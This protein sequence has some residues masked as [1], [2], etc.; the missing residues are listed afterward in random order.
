MKIERKLIYIVIGLILVFGLYPLKSVYAESYIR[1]GDTTRYSTAVAIA[2]EYNAGTAPNI[3]LTTGDGFADALSAAPFAYQLNAPVLLSSD[4]AET[5]SDAV[6]YI[7]SHTISSSVTYIIGGN[8]SV[9]ESISNALKTKVIRISGG[10]RYATNLKLAVA[11]NV[12]KGTPLVFASGES[13]PDALCIAGIAAHNGYPIL[14]IGPQG[15]TPELTDYILADAPK[16]MYFIGGDAVLPMKIQEALTSALPAASIL[17]LA[18]NDR[19]ETAAA[20]NNAFESRPSKV[21]ITTG[22]DF[23][24]ALAASSLTARDQAPLIYE[25]PLR[26]G[27]PLAMDRYL[28]AVYSSGSTPSVVALGGTHASPDWIVSE[29]AST[30]SGAIPDA[31]AKFNSIGSKDFVKL[32]D[33]VPNALYD[34]RYMTTNNFMSTVLYPS[35]YIPTVRKDMALRLATVA[36]NLFP[37]GYRLKFWDAYRPASAQQKMW[38]YR[39]DANYI[40]NPSGWGSNHEHGGAVDVTLTDLAGNEIQMPTDFDDAT[41]KASRSYSQCTL[42]QKANALILQNAMQAQGFVGLSTEWWHFDD[43]DVANDPLEDNAAPIDLPSPSFVPQATVMISATGDN[44]LANGYQFGYSGSFNESYDNNGPSYFYQKVHKILSQGDLSLGNLEGVLTTA[45]VRVDKSAQGEQAFWFKGRPVY[46]SAL[47]KQA[48]YDAVNIANNHSRDYMDTGFYDTVKAL[49][50]ADVGYFGYGHMYTT[51]RKGVK[52]AVLGYNVIGETEQFIDPNDNTKLVSG[53]QQEVI[54]AVKTDI[55]AAKSQGNQLVVVYYHWGTEGN[56]GVDEYQTAIGHATVDA[57]ANLVLGAH[58]H[59]LE[60]TEVYHGT[61]IVYSL[62][63]FVFGGNYEL[64]DPA[65]EISQTTFTYVNG[66]LWSTSNKSIPCLIS[67]SSSVNDFQ[68]ELNW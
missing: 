12:T 45:T 33:Y 64:Y 56:N 18:G 21:Y 10:D 55:A 7:N 25:E 60:P 54:N 14:L 40:A 68:P 42:E 63:N 20:V 6:N 46:A 34:I 49:E 15:L 8:V 19:Y 3:V 29:V 41:T 1:I 28:N 35:I 36:T 37:K 57:G 43:T 61:P 47:L 52:I 65:T 38:D 24:D 13:Y 58:P 22:A 23:A 30:L 44:T 51:T 5:S 67:S 32:A 66:E 9:P 59:V 31:L 17:R 39:P 4:S 27:A 48:P 26:S 62:G 11:M 50:E 53:R 2:K 16:T